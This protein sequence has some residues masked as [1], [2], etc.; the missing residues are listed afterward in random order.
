VCDGDL[1]AQASTAIEKIRVILEAAEYGL[2]DVV[3]VM[4]YVPPA[5]F[6]NLAE[7]D[8]LLHENGLGHAPRHTVP[9]TRL[10]RRDALIELEVIAARSQNRARQPNAMR[11]I[12]GRDS[13]TV[14]GELHSN[15][16]EESVEALLEQ[17]VSGI[18]AVLNE[19]RAGWAQ[20]V[21][22][23]LLVATEEYAALDK[24]ASHLA[25][26]V[27]Q[28][29][30]IPAVGVA[31]FPSGSG[32]A[33][34]SIEL[35]SGHAGG[36][37]TAVVA[38]GLVGRAGPFLVATGLRADKGEGITQQA[39]RIYGEVVPRLLESAGIGMESIVQTVE[40]LPVDALPDY[41]NTGPI[42]RNA[43]REPFPVS[44][45]LVCSALPGGAK[46][47]V[48]FLAIESGNP[49]ARGAG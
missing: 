44:S 12:S 25:Q 33:Q 14:F 18:N 19:A 15:R 5:A 4:Q 30:V 17:Q 22:C 31:A 41:R 8:D 34:F 6:G 48:D 42:R 38:S 43:L 27:P 46:I 9:V 29:P 2:Q 1:K 37:D 36:S 47:A 40:W 26:L 24:T 16:S 20:V 13:M 28:L 32:K 21:R 10:L 35:A 11:L 45:G 39:E 7:I 49:L 23:R 3:S